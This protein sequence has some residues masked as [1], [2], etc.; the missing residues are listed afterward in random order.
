MKDL[1]EKI[2]KALGDYLET[3]RKAFARFYFVGDED[4]LEIIGNSRD[5]SNVQRHFTKMYAGITSLLVDKS[6]KNGDQ[7]K[8]MTSREGES[9]NFD[10]VVSIAET[11][12]INEWLGK[13]DDQMRISL[14]SRLENSLKNIS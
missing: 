11:P 5:A 9:V 2:Q 13:I 1:L 12:K 4:L 7:V 3:Q 14:A 8:G 6:D 10:L